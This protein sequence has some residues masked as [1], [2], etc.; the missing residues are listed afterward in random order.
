VQQKP[1]IPTTIHSQLSHFTLQYHTSLLKENSGRKKD[2]LFM[3]CKLNLANTFKFTSSE[4]IPNFLKNATC[5]KKH[6]SYLGHEMEVN[7]RDVD[8]I[9]F[10]PK[11]Y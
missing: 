5:N 3:S 4:A 2:I 1:E 7:S 11:F 8:Y 10:H 6:V 9:Y